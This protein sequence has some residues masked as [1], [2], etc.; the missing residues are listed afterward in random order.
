MMQMRRTRPAVRRRTFRPA[1]GW[2]G[3][4]TLC[5]GWA[6]WA[7]TAGWHCGILR[8]LALITW[9]ASPP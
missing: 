4:R 1:R 3:A 8:F 5:T 7:R 6:R 2:A 9:R